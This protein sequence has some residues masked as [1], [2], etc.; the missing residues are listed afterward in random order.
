[1]SALRKFVRS[2][3]LV[4]SWV[5]YKA[6]PFPYESPTNCSPLGHRLAC[7][8]RWNMPCGRFSTPFA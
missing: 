5:L 1:M 8:A 7:T 4:I 6:G 2:R 3:K